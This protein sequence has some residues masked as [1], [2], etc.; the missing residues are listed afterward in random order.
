MIIAVANRKG[1]VGKTTMPSTWRT[2]RR[3]RVGRFCWS[4]W[5]R[6]ATLPIPWAWKRREICTAGSP[7]LPIER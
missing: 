3:W 4:T 6:K 7:G 5:T 2:A 1:G